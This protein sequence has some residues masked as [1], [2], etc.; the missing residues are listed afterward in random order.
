MIVPPLPVDGLGPLGR[1]DRGIARVEQGVASAALAGALLVSLYSIG[2]RLMRMPTG[3][4][5]LELPMELLV[6]LAIF[7]AGAVSAQRAHMRVAFLATRVTGPPA[8]VVEWIVHLAVLALCLLL[9]ARGVT[10]ARQAYRAGLHSRELFNAP[11]GLLTAIAAMGFIGWAAHALLA[12]AQLIQG[13]QA[14]TPD[15]GDAR[16]AH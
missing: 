11:V 8:R 14:R 15:A 7:G 10:S 16:A 12:V 9:A 1:L 6:L 4:W 2:M 5:V 3:E 13:T